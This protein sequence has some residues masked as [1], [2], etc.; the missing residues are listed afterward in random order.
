[1]LNTA[2]PDAVTAALR[3]TRRALALEQH[4]HTEEGA[5]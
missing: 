5:A 1:L 3:D 2:G 4:T